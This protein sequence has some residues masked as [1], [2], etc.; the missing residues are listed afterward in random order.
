MSYTG[1]RIKQLF[2]SSEPNFL[3]IWVNQKLYA[4]QPMYD[5]NSSEQII[6][7]WYESLLKQTNLF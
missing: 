7:N 2:D 5:N 4:P 1:V 6:T 3:E